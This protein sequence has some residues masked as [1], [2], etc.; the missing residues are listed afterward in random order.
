[1]SDN[2]RSSYGWRSTLQSSR[3]FHVED[4]DEDMIELR[5]KD[6]REPSN[7][8]LGGLLSII[9]AAAICSSLLLQSGCSCTP[10]PA[11]APDDKEKDPLAKKDKPKEDFEAKRILISPSDLERPQ[12]WMKPGHW[13]SSSQHLK[14]NNFDFLK[15]ELE[16]FTS[17]QGGRPYSIKNTNFNLRV[18][19]PAA[20]PK[21][22]GKNFEL[23]YFAPT[24]NDAPSKASLNCNLRY[25]G[26]SIR[27]PTSADA[28]SRLQPYQNYLVILARN[29]DDYKF[30]RTLETIK[31]PSTSFIVG[32]IPPT[33]YMLTVPN[34]KDRVDLP[35]SPMAWTS[36]SYLLWDN[37]DGAR[38][39]RD[40]QRAM[41]DWLH[42]GGQLIVSG[43]DSLDTLRA[44]FLGKHLPALPGKTQTISADSIAEINDY[45]SHQGLA[46]ALR[47]RMRLTIDWD[48]SPLEMIELLPQ[49]DGRFIEQTGRLVAERQIGRGRI[50]LTAFRLSARQFANWGGFDN[51]A[52]NALFRRPPRRFIASTQEESVIWRHTGL[53]TA[54][55]APDSRNESAKIRAPIESLLTSKIRY[56]SRD[57][58]S[59]SGQDG[60]DPRKLNLDV[61]GYLASNQSGVGGWNDGSPCAMAVNDS[62]TKSGGIEVPDAS[63]ILTALGGY[64]LILVPLNWIVFRLLGRVEWAWFAVPVIA[65]L[66]TY[67][68]VR[69]AQLDIGFARSRTELNILETQPGHERAHLSRFTGLYT[70]L[71]TNYELG[72]SDSSA[73]AL[74]FGSREYVKKNPR[75]VTLR[76]GGGKTGEG[77]QAT[78]TKVRMQGFAVESNNT[79]M[80][81]SE[82]MFDM[83]GKLSVQ[84]TNAGYEVINNT[85]YAIQ[86]VAAVTR[87]NQGI[88]TAWVGELAAQQKKTILFEPFN[89]G[90]VDFSQWEETEATKGT[91]SDGELQL[92][93]LLQMALSRNRVN[94]G[95]IRL[96]GWTD[97]VIPGL[98]IYPRASQAKYRSVIVA[99][100][101]YGQMPRPISDDNTLPHAKL[102]WETSN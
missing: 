2:S 18:M 82:Q 77:D 71:S 5:M 79:G 16:S 57:A 27:F 45:W 22:Q 93:S 7:R 3:D 40:Q 55:S 30:I 96:T 92:R 6:H 15:G 60:G 42:W 68:V 74:P 61:E 97:Q 66:G 84:A 90:L 24:W 65:I 99:N 48:A 10:K 32:S 11:T 78:R 4:H 63:F 80:V 88:E 21:G 43:P 29:P 54:V 19:R 50:V 58:S 100:L 75:T 28:T 36:I 94:N 33:D 76:M 53:S 39:N 56:F 14:A 34:T 85:D 59:P 81:H 67:F 72:F 101:R 38:L 23:T 46:E 52:N 69:L 102:A 98:V 13:Y 91:P 20:M 12:N 17:K 95:D 64:L 9:L 70:S 25:S 37:F 31:P 47:P 41:I 62:L 44:S 73:V 8:P 35:S 51:F 86:G 1:M 87:T 89:G 26:G 49:E 83:G